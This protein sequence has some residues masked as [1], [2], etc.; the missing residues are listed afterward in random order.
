MGGSRRM[1]IVA[2]GELPQSP[3]LVSPSL[4]PFGIVR[5]RLMGA[6]EDVARL[7]AEALAQAKRDAKGAVKT[8]EAAL[9]VANGTGIPDD[10]AV[11]CEHL[12]RLH[13][14][15]EKSRALHYAR[16]AVRLVPEEKSAH[17]TLAKTCELIAAQTNMETKGRRARALYGVV[18]T[19]FKKAAGM[20]K[21]PEDKRWLLELAH[22][23]SVASKALSR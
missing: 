10:A 11:V 23:A 1:L 2:Y 3:S 21:D 16:R 9:V 7:V 15:R 14:R 22:D 6:R 17:S 4:V 8:L 18:A 5:A 19:S 12:A 13:L 20:T